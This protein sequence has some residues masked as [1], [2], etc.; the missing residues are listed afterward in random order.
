[1]RFKR[2]T[3]LLDIHG[4]ELARWP[5]DLQIA[6]RRLV[7]ADPQAR[8]ALATA[9]RLSTLLDR[10]APPPGGEARLRVAAMLARLPAQQP[11]LW[12]PAPVMLWD[13]LPRWPRAAALA[14]MAALGIVVGLTDIGGALL[15]GSTAAPSGAPSGAVASSADI[16]ALI[17]DPNPAI[18]LGQ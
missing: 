12:W 17:Y 5:G 6:A 13:L 8:V 10:C 3:R 9:Q 4:P 18:G 2:F 11:P 1:V 16:S 14:T 7:A 15:S